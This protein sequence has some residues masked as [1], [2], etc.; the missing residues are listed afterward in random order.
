MGYNYD[1]TSNVVPQIVNQVAIV[2]FYKPTN[3]VSWSRKLN[4]MAGSMRGLP[5]RVICIYIYILYMSDEKLPPHRCRERYI[6]ITLNSW[7]GRWRERYVY[8]FWTPCP[9]ML[10]TVRHVALPWKDDMSINQEF[11]LWLFNIAMENGPFVDDFPIKTSIYKGF[12]MAMLNNQRVFSS[13]L[14]FRSIPN[15]R[16]S[17][18]HL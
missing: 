10:F 9:S 4:T 5:R 15:L 8:N 3:V 1:V 13:I 12:S 18:C 16:W 14:S 17:L 2:S 7:R 6:Y 11:T